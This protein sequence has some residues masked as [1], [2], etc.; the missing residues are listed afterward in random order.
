MFSSL[1]VKSL[2]T[3]TTNFFKPTIKFF[4]NSL[5]HDLI[6][7]ETWSIGNFQIVQC[8]HY[9]ID[10]GDN[11]CTSFSIPEIFLSYHEIN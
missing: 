1:E 6:V 4:Q 10:R 8:I 7:S 9:K 2:L 11:S 5:F 3:A